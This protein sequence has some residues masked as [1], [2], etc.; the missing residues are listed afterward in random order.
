M[1]RPTMVVTVRLLPSS[2]RLPNW[3]PARTAAPAANM[4]S[5]DTIISSS[6]TVT[7]T[8]A[9]AISSFSIPI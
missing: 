6:G 8:A 9:S 5:I 1:E 3:R 4:F 2:S 7:P